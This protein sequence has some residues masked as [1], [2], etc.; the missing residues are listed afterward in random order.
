M[1]IIQF[2]MNF[3]IFTTCVI[4]VNSMAFS[5][6]TEQN[7][8]LLFV[9]SL[10]SHINYSHQ[11]KCDTFLCKFTKTLKYVQTPSKVLCTIHYGSTHMW[12][13]TD[14]TNGGT[15]ARDFSLDPK[16]KMVC[17]GFDS[18]EVPKEVIDSC[19]L[20]YTI[21]PKSGLGWF[22]YYW[23]LTRFGLFSMV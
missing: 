9:S 4:L 2:T 7:I 22:I 16:Y 23:M 12:K 11:M 17:D 1:C 10:D 20:K 18:H 14:I 8:Q 3:M 13:C 21:I 15:S 19:I 5:Q 6:Y